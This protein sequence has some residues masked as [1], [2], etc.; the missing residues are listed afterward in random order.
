MI[1]NLQKNPRPKSQEKKLLKR[2]DWI[3]I[4]VVRTTPIRTT[5]ERKK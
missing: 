1:T 2:D 5:D 3:K 4:A